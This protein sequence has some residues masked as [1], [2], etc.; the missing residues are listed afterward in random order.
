MIHTIEPRQ[1]RFFDPFD[2]VIPPTR[3]KIIAK[4]W[5]GVF[6]H[7]LLEVMPVSELA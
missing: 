7:V 5:Q 1:N 3:R 2:G 6:R 4:G